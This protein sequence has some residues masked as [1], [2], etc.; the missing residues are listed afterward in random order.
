MEKYAGFW[1]RFVA[2]TVD[3]IIVSIGGAMAQFI[4][5]IVLLK[6]ISSLSATIIGGIIP[7]IGV[8]LYYILMTQYKGATLGKMLV[9][10]TV[11][12]EDGITP[13]TFWRLVLREVVGKFVSSIILGIGY[14]MAAFTEKKQGLHDMM[15]KTVVVYKDPANPNKTGLVIGIIIAVLL[16]IIAI[17]GILSS[18]VLMSLSTARGVA[19]EARV[20]SILNSTAMQME[21]DKINV[22]AYTV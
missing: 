17:V 9:G 15:A 10:I 13:L 21:V 7:M 12:S 8:W 20:K 16:P 22:V 18:V 14:I 6:T 4:I 19:D 5:S 1:I 11:K 3:G 2:S